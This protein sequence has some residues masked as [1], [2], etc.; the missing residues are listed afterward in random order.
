MA[1]KI[2]RSGVTA[3]TFEEGQRIERATPARLLIRLELSADAWS[4]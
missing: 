4:Q 2:Q 1:P 3:A